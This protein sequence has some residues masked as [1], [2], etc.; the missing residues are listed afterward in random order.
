MLGAITVVLA[1][2]TSDVRLDPAGLQR[3]ISQ[4][5]FIIFACV[6]VVAAIVLAGLS[7]GKLGRKVVFVDVGLCAIFG[8]CSFSGVVISTDDFLN[9]L[10]LFPPLLGGFT[11]LATK[12]I[13]TLLTLEWWDMF[14]ESITYPV[15]LVS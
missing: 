10:F 11:V 1:S 8:G 14:T 6:Y 5:P 13:S 4:R 7:E 2:N 9:I 3:A 12:A 15:I